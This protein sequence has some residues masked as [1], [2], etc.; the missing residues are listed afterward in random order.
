MKHLSDEIY[1][2]DKSSQSCIFC[3]KK[4][5]TREHIPAQNLYKGIATL[6]PII[7]PSCHQCNKGLSEDEEYFRNL[8]SSL[9]Y[10]ESVSASALFETT[11]KRS[12]KRRPAL[13]LSILEQMSHVNLYSP[14]G[15]YLGK[16]TAWKLTRDDHK[17]IYRV[18][19]KY[20]KGLF[21]HHFGKSVPADWTV[22]HV[23]LMPK[24]EEMLGKA[25]KEFK[26]VILNENVFIYGFNS[27][28]ETHQS[29]WCLAFYGKPFF[30]SFI[31]DPK[32]AKAAKRKF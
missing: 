2:K 9:R 14:G 28:P 11:I 6:K 32:T 12:M 31:L 10:D 8:I 27:T 22:K 15:I 23:W 20:V 24:N 18:L 4:A 5:N 29:I 13:G 21:F 30:F 25:A 17:R 1:K 3:N 16:K 7:V 26:W 19:D